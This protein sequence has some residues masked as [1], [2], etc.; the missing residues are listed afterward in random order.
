MGKAKRKQ[1]GVLPYVKQ[2]QKTRII[3][4]TGRNSK[5]WIVPKG[6]RARNKSKRES[7]LLEAYEEAGLSGQMKGDLKFRISITSH[8]KKVAL[9]L[10][11]MRVNKHLKKKWPESGQRKRIKVSCKQAQSLVLWPKLGTCI[12]SLKKSI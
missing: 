2:S 5:Q 6:N 4:I 8:G 1:Y 3:L 9:T 12:K 11:P 7:A 10:Y